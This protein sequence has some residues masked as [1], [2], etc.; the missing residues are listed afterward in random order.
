M[1]F[2]TKI[3]LSFCV[4]GKN[5]FFFADEFRKNVEEISLTTIL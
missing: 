4:E 3:A 1:T 2:W 5:W